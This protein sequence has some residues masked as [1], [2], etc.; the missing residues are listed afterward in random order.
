MT[1]ED[2]QKEFAVRY[3]LWATEESRMEI[4]RGFPLLKRLE[5]TT[6]RRYLRRMT[7]LTSGEQ[8]A[9]ADVMVKRFHPQALELSGE[10]LTNEEVYEIKKYTAS[11][12]LEIDPI[13]EAF[14][15][16]E[17]HGDRTTKLDR[18]RFRRIL[19][20]CLVPILGHED[21]GGGGGTW[22][23]TTNVES[24]RI[25]TYVDTGG[26]QHQLSYFHRIVFSRH[27]TLHEGISVLDWLGL[28]S[29]TQWRQIEDSKAEATAHL[30]AELCSHFLTIAPRLLK[31]LSPE[32]A[33]SA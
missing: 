31:G 33:A 4:E 21:K 16:R 2:A 5:I 22:C 29:A 17:I 6:C 30:L 11:G 7:Q 10:I 8:R 9:F 24:V 19:K 12:A 26:T 23:Y 13:E 15:Q 28:S 25:L 20:Q 3:Y 27:Q 32:V 1:F 14:F 18:K